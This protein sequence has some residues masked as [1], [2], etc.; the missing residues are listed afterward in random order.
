MKPFQVVTFA[1]TY[2]LAGC[3]TDE[4]S[5]QASELGN[6]SG[7]IFTTTADGSRVDANIYAHKA[8]VYLDGGPG[9]KAPRSAAALPD[10][11]YYFQVTDPS[12][13]ALLSED[14][15]DCRRVRFAGGEIAEVY[16][17]AGGRHVTGSDASDGGL[18]VQLMPYADTPNPGCEYK[19][20]VTP[21]LRYQGHFLPRYSKTDNFKVC[22]KSTPPPPPP[23]TCVCGNGILEPGEEC[24]DGN[25]VSGD[26]CSS[27]CQIET[28]S[29]NLQ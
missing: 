6:V 26:G 18:T 20:W 14:A 19:V 21:A 8:D 5:E 16:A 24:D 7:A 17:C 12:G 25:T 15:I 2:T 3:A 23:P 27:T 11:D 22:E 9:A 13:H 4:I 28:C 29:G 10:G 1:L